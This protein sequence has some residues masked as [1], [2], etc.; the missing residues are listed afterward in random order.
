MTIHE[1][2]IDQGRFELQLTAKCVEIA[3]STARCKLGLIDRT[4][5]MFEEER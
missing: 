5:T 2:V 3:Q 1:S 4:L